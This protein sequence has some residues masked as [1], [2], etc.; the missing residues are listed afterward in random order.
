MYPQ[1]CY[2]AIEY[3]NTIPSYNCYLIS[4]KYP[5]WV[6]FPAL[7]SPHDYICNFYEVSQMWVTWGH[8]LVFLFATYFPLEKDP[9]LHPHCCK[10]QILSFPWLLNAPLCFSYCLYSVI[11][12]WTWSYLL[13]ILF[14][15]IKWCLIYCEKK[16]KSCQNQM[17]SPLLTLK[18]INRA[19]QEFI[20][21]L[22]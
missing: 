3:P 15:S 7:M 2:I 14:W 9:S 10:G 19:D 22:L 1:L 18:K 20:I 8:T 21:A 4:I 6:L 17:V 16:C 11:S 5:F 12:G 13:K